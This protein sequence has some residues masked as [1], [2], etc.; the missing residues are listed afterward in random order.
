MALSEAEQVRGRE[1]CNNVRVNLN[2]FRPAAQE[3][4]PGEELVEHT[5][6]TVLCNR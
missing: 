2:M 6:G 5:S 3:E 4:R 1:R